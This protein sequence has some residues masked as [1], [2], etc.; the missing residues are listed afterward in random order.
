ME[1]EKEIDILRFRHNDVNF[2]T[3]FDDHQT[4]ENVH[5]CVYE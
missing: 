3:A 5:K 1:E 2:K 4:P